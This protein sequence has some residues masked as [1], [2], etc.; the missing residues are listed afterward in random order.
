MPFRRTQG[1]PFRGKPALQNR[2]AP[3]EPGRRNQRGYCTTTVMRVKLKI[4]GKR[5]KSQNQQLSNLSFGALGR[6]K[7]SPVRARAPGEIKGAVPGPA[8][9]TI[10]V[11]HRERILKRRWKVAWFG[12]ASDARDRAEIFVDGPQVMIS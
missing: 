8:S 4:R 2:N 9:K 5:K 6:R 7:S 3:A 12:R 11:Q 10:V 1:K